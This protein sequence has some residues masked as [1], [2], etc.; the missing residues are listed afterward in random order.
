MPLP[1]VSIRSGRSTLNLK[2]LPSQVAA[3]RREAEA[4]EGQQAEARKTV[5]IVLVE[6]NQLQFAGATERARSW[7]SELNRKGESQHLLTFKG[8]IEARASKMAFIVPDDVEGEDED[9]GEEENKDADEAGG[10]ESKE[11]S[12]EDGSDDGEDDEEEDGSDAGE[13][14]EDD[15]DSKACHEYFMD[16]DWFYS[17]SFT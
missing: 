14:E 6:K 16:F 3:A 4:G 15:V 17:S 13:D 11:D 8:E 5:N 1:N 10:E 7:K 12:E 2:T 9:D